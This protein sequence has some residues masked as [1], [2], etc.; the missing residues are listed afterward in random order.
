MI[1]DN[2]LLQYSQEIIDNTFLY[3]DFNYKVF[4]DLLYGEKQVNY[5][6]LA[7]YLD[8][9][10]KK[11]EIKI[12]KL[13]YNEFIEDFI[14]SYQKIIK[15]L[16]SSYVLFSLMNLQK[17]YSNHFTDLKN[18]KDYKKLVSCLVKS[19][20]LLPLNYRTAVSV[21]FPQYYNLTKNKSQP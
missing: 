12:P 14:P 2:K 6:F 13:S 16:P 9:L 5:F 3:K 19:D 11:I 21:Y 10:S 18:E 17:H 20:N 15:E 1:E 4:N 7:T 8:C